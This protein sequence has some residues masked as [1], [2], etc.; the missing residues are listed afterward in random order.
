M[1][2]LA[3]LRLVLDVDLLILL[4]EWSGLEAIELLELQIYTQFRRRLRGGVYLIVTEPCRK[5]YDRFC[6]WAR[7]VDVE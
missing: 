1:E 7:Y 5:Y 3:G 2:L 6:Q 4:V